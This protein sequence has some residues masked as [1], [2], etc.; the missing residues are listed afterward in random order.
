MAN[1]ELTLRGVDTRAP[2]LIDTVN[3]L[4]DFNVAYELSRLATD[5]R[6][7]GFHFSRFVLYR[8][9][10]PLESQDRLFIHE[11]EQASPFKLVARL[12]ATSLAIGSLWGIVQ[13]AQVVVNWP[14]EHRKLEAE[15]RKSELEV[16]KLEKKLGISPIT[17]RFRRAEG[18]FEGGVWETEAKPYLNNLVNRFERSP[19][20][21]EDVEVRVVKEDTN[22]S[23]RRRRQ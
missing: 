8:N 17:T 15:V 19:V 21:I 20:R 1:I 12:T 16:V 5:P 4:Y 7:E 18:P 3:F 11:L 13:I 23:T 22:E 14:L 6:Y 9:G 10:R 2:L